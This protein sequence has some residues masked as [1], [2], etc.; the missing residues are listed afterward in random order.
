MCER[1]IALHM[2][3]RFWLIVIRQTSDPRKLGLRFSRSWIL[4]WLNC[5]FPH[6]IISSKFRFLWLFRCQNA[7]SPNCHSYSFRH[8]CPLYESLCSNINE[9]M[10]K[11][12]PIIWRT[13]ILKSR[14]W[15]TLPGMHGTDT[16]IS[17]NHV[18]VLDLEYNKSKFFNKY[19]IINFATK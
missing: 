9:N 15:N 17:A 1:T 14:Y 2:V 5:W 12:D 11:V 4:W 19:V 8:D 18:N 3:S 10:Q 16:R 13:G 6:I 7:R